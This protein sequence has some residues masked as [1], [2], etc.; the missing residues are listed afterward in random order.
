MERVVGKRMRTIDDALDDDWN[1]TGPMRAAS[2]STLSSLDK[3]IRRL[4]M[5]NASAE[6]E[7][8]SRPMHKYSARQ[9]Q[10]FYEM[11]GAIAQ[12]IDENT[13]R[14]PDLETQIDLRRQE[15]AA[16]ARTSSTSVSIYKSTTPNIR[17]ASTGPLGWLQQHNT[18][19]DARDGAGGGMKLSDTWSRQ[20]ATATQHAHSKS[21]TLI[22]DV[23]FASGCGVLADT[24]PDLVLNNVLF[25][26]RTL[27]LDE[28][29]I[30]QR[31]SQHGTFVAFANNVARDAGASMSID[32]LLKRAPTIPVFAVRFCHDS[33][34]QIVFHIDL[35]LLYFGVLVFNLVGGGASGATLSAEQTRALRAKV[36]EELAAEH[37]ADAEKAAEP[38]STISVLLKDA[39]MREEM[40]RLN[41]LNEELYKDYAETAASA[42]GT[43]VDRLLAR[44]CPLAVFAPTKSATLLEAR[45]AFQYYHFSVC[46]CVLDDDDLALYKRAYARFLPAAGTGADS[47]NESAAAAATSATNGETKK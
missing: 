20:A 40:E 46:Q 7:N 47:D 8:R 27:P 11:V 21:D 2:E 25:P 18:K 3:R 42:N 4:D 19:P 32:A 16:H 15:A 38:L 34:L 30:L 31:M 43:R 24:V 44:S 28:K 17:Y 36:V 6:P 9:Q 33:K 23:R 5:K 14:P 35:D 12:T 29:T 13:V 26:Y 37:R 45:I 10:V 39:D 1:V 41:R 22:L